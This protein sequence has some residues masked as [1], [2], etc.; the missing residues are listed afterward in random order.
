LNIFEFPGNE[1]L[2]ILKTACETPNEGVLEESSGKDLIQNNEFL[3]SLFNAF[4][5][6]SKLQILN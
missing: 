2:N 1:M 6:L 3:M 4:L 5:I